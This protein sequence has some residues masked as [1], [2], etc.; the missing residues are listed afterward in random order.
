[1][2]H[3]NTD[4]RSSSTPLLAAIFSALS[5]RLLVDVIRVTIRHYSSLLEVPDP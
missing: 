2:E 1:M 5:F 3:E 4:T